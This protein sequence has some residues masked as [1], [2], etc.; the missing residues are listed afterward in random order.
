MVET[1]DNN[2]RARIDDNE[3]RVF[4][5][6]DNEDSASALESDTEEV[7]EYYQQYLEEYKGYEEN[8]PPS[9][10]D[11]C[12]TKCDYEK[13]QCFVRF[14]KG[15]AEIDNMWKTADDIERY[16]DME[17]L[18]KVG[19]IITLTPLSCKIR[20]MIYMMKSSMIHFS[21]SNT[22]GKDYLQEMMKKKQAEIDE[23]N[24]EINKLKHKLKQIHDVTNELLKM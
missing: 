20:D 8:G 10:F 6:L 15:M 4:F 5:I 21:E 12:L 7:D 3:D 1:N 9:V 13:E 19:C 2:K 18:D 24:I 17:M 14:S 23:K 16:I 11:T 22:H